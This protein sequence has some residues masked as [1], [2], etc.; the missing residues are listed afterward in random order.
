MLYLMEGL[1]NSREHGG[2]F[3]PLRVPHPSTPGSKAAPMRNPGTSGAVLTLKYIRKEWE[4]C[5]HAA[6][7]GGAPKRQETG[8]GGSTA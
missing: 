8:G 1:Q 7:D 4:R 5:R 6:F 3:P 2:Q